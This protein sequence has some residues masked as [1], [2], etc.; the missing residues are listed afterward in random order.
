MTVDFRMKFGPLGALMERLAVR[1]Q[2]CKQMALSLASLKYH[3]ETGEVVGS[4]LPKAALAAVS[5]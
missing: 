3:V 4:K 5:L 2:M 1:R